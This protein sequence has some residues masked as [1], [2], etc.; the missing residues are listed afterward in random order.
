M[1]DMPDRMVD[2]LF[3]FLE[4]N[5]GRLSKRA[6]KGEFKNLTVEEVARAENLYE[7][8]FGHRGV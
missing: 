6:R 4:Q 3:R 5:E 8:A 1:V 2:L 7:Q